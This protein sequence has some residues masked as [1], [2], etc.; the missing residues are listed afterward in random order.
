MYRSLGTFLHHAA[1]YHRWTSYEKH[2]PKTIVTC[3]MYVCI[4]VCACVCVCVFALVYTYCAGVVCDCTMSCSSPL[5]YV[6]AQCHVHPP[7]L[8]GAFYSALVKAGLRV[9]S[10]NMNYGDSGNWWLFINGTDPAGQLAW[11]RDELQKAEIAGEKVSKYKTLVLLGHSFQM[12][13]N[14]TMGLPCCLI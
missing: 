13:S 8:S 10:L 14:T 7:S 5:W 6:T 12:A 3:I 2:L 9:I 1:V 11:L 4:C